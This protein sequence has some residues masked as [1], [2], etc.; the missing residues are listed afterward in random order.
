[1]TSFRYRCAQVVGRI[2]TWLCRHLGV[3]S[4]SV[5]PGRVILMIDPDFLTTSR[6][7]IHRDCIFITGTNGKST[8]TYYLHQ[9]IS[10]LGYRVMSNLSGAN[11]RAGLAAACAQTDKPVDFGVFE[12]DEASVVQVAPE[13]KPT[14]L[15][16]LNFS[17]DQMDRY[18]EIEEII[19]KIKLAIGKK[20][21]LVYN[22][23]NPYAAILSHRL[24][25]GQG[26]RTNHALSLQPLDQPVCP[27]CYAGLLHNESTNGNHA[28]RCSNCQM[29]LAGDK[30]VVTD[31]H[32][33][34]LKIF[35]Q[36][37]GCPS[38]ELAE[39]LTAASLTCQSLGFPQ[40]QILQSLVRVPPLPAHERRYRTVQGNVV[41]DLAL[42]KNPESFNR[43]LRRNLGRYTSIALAVNCQYADGIDAS[44]LWDVNFELLRELGLP[45]TVMGEASHDLGLRL[46]VAGV[47]RFKCSDITELLNGF[48]KQSANI[49]IIANYTAYRQIE[50]ALEQP[51]NVDIRREE[52]HESVDTYLPAV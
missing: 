15:I 49:M 3:G 31:Y 24:G 11:M 34:I 40:E 42:A 27:H 14:H 5:L 45:V 25:R 20:A 2:V 41:I 46:Q 21:R 17:R 37:I 48:R 47:R 52:L 19:Q 8:T 7:L 38:P 35:D 18:T 12:V 36:V 28:I 23:A 10:S 32:D 43:I 6:Q 9:A 30:T 4:G 22:A 13:L 44:W 51:I 33:G 26:Y 29:T 39:A 16:A 50:R 1:M